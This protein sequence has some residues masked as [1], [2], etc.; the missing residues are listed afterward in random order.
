[1]R[2][3]IADFAGGAAKDKY[4]RTR[5]FVVNKQASCTP[6]EA[7][8]AKD[9]SYPSGQTSLGWTW[10]L[11][12]SEVGSRAEQCAAGTWLRLRAKPGD[13]RRPLAKRR[14]RRPR[15]RR[16]GHQGDARLHDGGSRIE[17]RERPQLHPRRALSSCLCRHERERYPLDAPA[18]CSTAIDPGS[19]GR[20]PPPPGT[21][22]R[23]YT[24]PPAHPG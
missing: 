12:L 1:L 19:M 20:H 23:S 3:G 5:P 7:Y 8:L 17:V 21:E 22:R 24:T 15:Y 13:L 6:Q 4:Q 11:I 2:A 16:K 14:Q 10:A 18:C 9:G